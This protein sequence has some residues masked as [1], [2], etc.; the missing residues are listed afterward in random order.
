[1]KVNIGNYPGSRSKKPQKIQVRID[2]WDT[3]SLDTTLAQIIHPALIKFKEERVKVPG[4]PMLFFNETDD[5]CEYGNYTD[6]SLEKAEKRYIEWLD[7]M[8]WAFNEIANQNPGEEE[9]YGVSK[10]DNKAWEAYHKRIEDA[11]A[12]FGK[13]FNTL[14]W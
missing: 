13:K 6:E 7:E 9:F 10:I 8:I 3:F 14:W 4:V 2:R 11:C 12:S 1:M 5:K